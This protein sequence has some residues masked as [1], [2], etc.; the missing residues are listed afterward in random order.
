MPSFISTQV[1]ASGA[2]QTR[3]IHVGF[4]YGH[5][6]SLTQPLLIADAP[7]PCAMCLVV[8]G[9]DV[10]LPHGLASDQD[11][12]FS[13]FPEDE[14]DSCNGTLKELCSRSRSM[15]FM[16]GIEICRWSTRAAAG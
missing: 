2:W 6:L 9:G 16:S 12:R 1:A 11:Q 14:G 15:K 5:G 7:C 4:G 10:S 13:S 3:P 8:I